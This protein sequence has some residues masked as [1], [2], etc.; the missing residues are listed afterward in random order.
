VKI[1]DQIE[2]L[3]AQPSAERH[4]LQQAANPSPSRHHDHLVERRI[5]RDDGCGQRLDEVAD[6]GAGK[7]LPESPDG[8]GRKDD[9]SDLA[10]ADDENAQFLWLHCGFVDQHDR[11][12]V[13]NRVDAM[14]SR[15]FQC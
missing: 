1:D 6:A 2:M 8:R 9:V 13:F 12:V 3:R 4:I 5:V 11:N 14:T 15:A 7:V 10:Q